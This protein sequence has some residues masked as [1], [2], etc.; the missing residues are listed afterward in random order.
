[1]RR[2]LLWVISIT[3]A[4]HFD[5]RILRVTF[6]PVEETGRGVVGPTGERKREYP[7][8]RPRLPWRRLRQDVFR[9]QEKGG[10]LAYRQIRF[11]RDA[12]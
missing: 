10:V 1:M 7:L 8:S 4:R 11:E 6:G 5:T 12:E 3:Q 9:R 2:Y